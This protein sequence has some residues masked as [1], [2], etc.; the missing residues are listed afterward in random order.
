LELEDTTINLVD[1]EDG[2]NL[3][4]KSLTKNSLSLDTNAFD[5]IDDDECT[6]SDM[7]GSGNF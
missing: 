1:E 6:V 2:L 3:F 4:T 5:V 7:E